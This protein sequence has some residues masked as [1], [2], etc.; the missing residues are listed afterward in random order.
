MKLAHLKGTSLGTYVPTHHASWADD[1]CVFSGTTTLDPGMTL[2]AWERLSQDTLSL[3]FMAVPHVM[4]NALI[5]TLKERG[6]AK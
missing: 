5:Y 4:H 1:K 6:W 3:Q 2:W